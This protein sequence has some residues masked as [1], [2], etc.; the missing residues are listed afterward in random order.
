MA[1]PP[2]NPSNESVSLESSPGT[3]VYLGSAERLEA[4]K[5]VLMAFVNVR[6]FKLSVPR[7]LAAAIRNWESYGEDKPRFLRVF[8]PE[9][10]DAPSLDDF[11]VRIGVLWHLNNCLSQI[12]QSGE[13]SPSLLEDAKSLHAKLARAAL[14]LFEHDSILGK[15]V[16]DIRTGSGYLD[17]ADD[18]SRYAMLFDQNFEEIKDRCDINR[19]DIAAANHVSAKILTVLSKDKSAETF[20]LRDLRNR[21]AEY[22]VRGTHQI[23]RAAKYVFG[24]NRQDMY[25]YPSLYQRSRPRKKSETEQPPAETTE[26][27]VQET[28]DN[29]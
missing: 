27:N 4:L 5:P 29:Q 18:L 2:T 8:T 22:L 20:E 13:L 17:I 19:I 16:M 24:E 21:A 28:A 11:P 12:I 7:T 6:P 15:V 1:E 10:F 23:R 9:G 26:A 25:R 14:Y 3:G